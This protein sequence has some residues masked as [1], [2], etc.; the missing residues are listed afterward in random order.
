MSKMARRTTRTTLD[1]LPLFA[2]D[3]E[4]AEAVVGRAR[5]ESWVRDYLPKLQ[6]MPGFPPLDESH[7]GRYT[8]SV[9]VFYDRRSGIGTAFEGR[10]Q[11]E[12]A[13]A[14]RRNRRAS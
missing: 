13:S 6:N 12:N 7:G 14:F 8:P 9:K 2:T 3:R 5:A 1:D 11:P 10:D 4:I